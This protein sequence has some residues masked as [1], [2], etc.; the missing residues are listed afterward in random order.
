MTI[1][2][3]RPIFGS[4][5]GGQNLGF[6]VVK[7]Q[8]VVF[9]DEAKPLHGPSGVL[10]KMTLSLAYKSRGILWFASVGG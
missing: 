8:L 1:D 6:M 3:P 2:A 7:L 5:A 4:L 10:D 9:T